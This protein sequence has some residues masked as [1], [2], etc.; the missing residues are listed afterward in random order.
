VPLFKRY[1]KQVSIRVRDLMSSPPVVMSARSSVD[2]AAKVMWEKRVGSLLVVDEQDRLVGLVTERD[3]IFAAARSMIGRNTPVS[4]IM[5]K[6]LITA[7]PDED[8]IAAVEKMRQANV[9]HLPVMD[10]SGQPVGMLSIRDVL[11]AAMLFM[12]ILI[13]SE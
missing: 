2:E 9:R 7:R 8:V 10:E 12:K 5:A 1:A 6:N 11:D 4:D 13:Q 3:I